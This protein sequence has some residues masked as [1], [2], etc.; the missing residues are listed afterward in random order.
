MADTL[1]GLRMEHEQDRNGF[2]KAPADAGAF[3]AVG[4]ELPGDEND[5]LNDADISQT[6]NGAKAITGK[7]V[8]AAGSAANVAREDARTETENRHAEQRQSFEDEQ[9]AEMAHLS[10]WN[11]EMTTIGGV[12]MTNADAQRL[13]QFV[14]DHDDYY[15]HEAVREGLIKDSEVEAFKEHLHRMKEL[16]DKRGRGT[17]TA[18]EQEEEERERHSRF[19]R[20]EDRIYAEAA[21]NEYKDDVS[22][23]P[24]S[25]AAQQSRKSA[26]SQYDQSLFPTAAPVSDHFTAA[27]NNTSPTASPTIAP[28]AQPAATQKQVAAFQNI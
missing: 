26:A 14:I 13:R 21:K 28:S 1:K 15:A 20:A 24:T 8:W 11:A 10:K 6:L 9:Q 18:A 23:L 27:V 25:N 19:G 12:R 16:E 2:E 22:A 17:M 3:R 4:G 7:A 5:S